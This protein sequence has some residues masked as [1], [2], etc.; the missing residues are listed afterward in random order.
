MARP[1]P[2]GGV[3]AAG[4]AKCRAEP[5]DFGQP[6]LAP[7]PDRIGMLSRMWDSAAS[8]LAWVEFS[9]HCW[10]CGEDSTLMSCTLIGT[11]PISE[12]TLP[13]AGS[14]MQGL[15]SEPWIS[16]NDGLM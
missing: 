13:L 10:F 8:P 6:F 16:A 12:P 7:F 1:R 5:W 15:L 9:T 4:A 11:N 3:P 2:A 14:A